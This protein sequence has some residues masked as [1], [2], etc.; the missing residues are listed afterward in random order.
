MR[1]IRVNLKTKRLELTSWQYL[2]HFYFALIPLAI[3]FVTV[4]VDWSIGNGFLVAI[5]ISLI[6]IL[7]Q[8]RIL[9][10]KEFKINCNHQDLIDAM[11]RSARSLDWNVESTLDVIYAYDKEVFEYRYNTGYLIVIAKTNSGFIFNSLSDPRKFV[12]PLLKPY[13]N[14]NLEVF[15]KH[16]IDIVKGIDYNEAF[17]SLSNEWTFKKILVRIFLYPL[18]LALIA[19]FFYFLFNSEALSFKSFIASAIS[20]IVSVVYLIYDIK[21]IVKLGTNNNKK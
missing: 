8:W 20:F 2:K 10:F 1:D 18:S 9:K 12:V 4:S 21:G 19:L 3:Y 11:H 17:P 14:L 15:K 5:A 16:L 7:I 13:Y 6:V